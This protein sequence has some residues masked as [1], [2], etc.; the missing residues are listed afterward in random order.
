MRSGTVKIIISMLK[1]FML[2]S[3]KYYTTQYLYSAVYLVDLYG[4]IFTY[5][6]YFFLPGT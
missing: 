1:K 5:G 2:T 3:K 4:N 6:K